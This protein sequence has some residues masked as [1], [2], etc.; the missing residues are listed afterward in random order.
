[1]LHVLIS[2]KLVLTELV[3][4]PVQQVPTENNNHLYVH[5]KTDIM[6]MV[7]KSVKLVT[8]L[9]SLVSITKNVILLVLVTEKMPQLVI[10]H[11]NIMIMV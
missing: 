9:V 7:L 10:A 5:V 2:V 3:V 1:V 6:M 8:I 4:I 11:Q